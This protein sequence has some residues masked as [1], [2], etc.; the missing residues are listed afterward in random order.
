MNTIIINSEMNTIIITSEMNT[1][2]INTK[3]LNTYNYNYQ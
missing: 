3:Q 1:I 2:I